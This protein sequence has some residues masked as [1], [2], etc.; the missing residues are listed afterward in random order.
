MNLTKS[1]S[2]STNKLK[3]K[4][5]IGLA[6][7]LATGGLGIGLAATAHA[8]PSHPAVAV[9]QPANEATTPGVADAPGGPDVQSGLQQGPNVQSGSQTAPDTAAPGSAAA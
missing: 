8:S 5:G 3:F 6:A 2:Q 1:I 9:T 4:A 7:L